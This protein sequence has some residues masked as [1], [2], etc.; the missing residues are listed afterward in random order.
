M[1]H[2]GLALCGVVAPAWAALAPDA[3]NLL[4]LQVMVDFVEQHRAVAMD[5]RSLDVVAGRVYWGESCE[6]RFERPDVWHPPGWT[7]PQPRLE[8]VGSNCDPDEG[9]R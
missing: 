3:Q 6:A 2:L 1:R 8:Y 7:G 4:D 5:L 9:A